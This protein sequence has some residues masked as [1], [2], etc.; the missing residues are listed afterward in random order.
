MSN[1]DENG[2][3]HEKNQSYHRECAPLNNS[4]I[5]KG[6]MNLII[7]KN[8]IQYKTNTTVNSNRKHKKNSNNTPQLSIYRPLMT[9]ER[10]N[11]YQQ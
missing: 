9:L 5:S 8:Q 11:K 1:I 7:E 2:N 6:I 10:Q 4:Y 3:R